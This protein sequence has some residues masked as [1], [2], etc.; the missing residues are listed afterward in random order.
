MRAALAAAGVATLFLIGC[1]SDGADF[2]GADVEDRLAG[3]LAERWDRPVDEVSCPD[4]PAARSGSTFRCTATVDGVDGRLRV[5]VAVG[6]DDRLDVVPLD[7]LVDRAAVAA[8]IRRLLVQRHGRPFEATCGE[9]SIV[10]EPGG[11]VACAVVDGDEEPTVTVTVTDAAG[12]LEV[13]VSR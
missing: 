11:T 1:G 8:E 12:T 3:S 6:A 4:R 13:A 7:A 5:E 10:V 9:G 2:D